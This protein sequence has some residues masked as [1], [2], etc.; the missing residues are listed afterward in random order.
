MG[1]GADLSPEG[2][3]GCLRE[4]PSR[5][6]ALCQSFL[7][8]SDACK[9]EL[10]EGGVCGADAKQGDGIVCLLSRA[11]KSKISEDCKGKFP[12]EKAATGLRDTLWKNGK[13]V[14]EDEEVES[15]SEEDRDVYE[16]WV[17]RKNKKNPRAKDREYALRMKKISKAKEIM[18]YEAT[19]KVKSMVTDGEDIAAIEKTAMKSIKS[20]YKKLK[21]ADKTLE[22]SKKDLKAMVRD[23]VTQAKKEI[24]L[25]KKEEL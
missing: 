9:G 10:S 15:L 13:R 19:Q 2:I 14:L 17:E 24:A 6:S 20:K 12:E 7:D 3:D 16:R 8:I 25:G 22:I 1:E 23:V 18:L 21:A 4:D 11:D 5:L